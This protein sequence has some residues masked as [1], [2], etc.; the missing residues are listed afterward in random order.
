[1]TFEFAGGCS[2]NPRSPKTGFPFPSQM[3]TPTGR[4]RSCRCWTI[5]IRRSRARMRVWG[6]P[7]TKIKR[8]PRTLPSRSFVRICRKCAE[9]HEKVFGVFFSL[10]FCRCERESKY[11]KPAISYL[12]VFSSERERE[13]AKIDIWK[14][15]QRK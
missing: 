4:C 6:R 7:C 13:T 15:K 5:C 14:R 1:M 12:L 9:C 11:R 8:T 2:A 10:L 3:M